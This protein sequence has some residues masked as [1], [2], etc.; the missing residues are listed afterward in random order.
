MP[1]LG[2]DVDEAIAKTMPIATEL[3]CKIWNRLMELCIALSFM[4]TLRKHPWI[5]GAVIFLAMAFFLPVGILLLLCG[6]AVMGKAKAEND[7]IVPVDIEKSGD[8]TG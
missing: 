1:N 7:F 6:L 8:I 2:K 4:P 3:L 5:F